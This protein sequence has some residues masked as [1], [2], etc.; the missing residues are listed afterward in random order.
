MEPIEIPTKVNIGRYRKAIVAVLGAVATIGAVIGGAVADD[1]INVS[2]VIE[3][4][5]VIGAAT[6]VYAIR[7]DD[8]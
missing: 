4:I 7:N 8:A 2:E 6:G 1:E 5:S 3:I